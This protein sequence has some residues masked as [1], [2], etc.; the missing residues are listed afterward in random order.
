MYRLPLIGE[1]P[2]HTPMGDGSEVMGDMLA[3][4]E[5]KRWDHIV[6]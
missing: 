6:H 3:T 5:A 1:T 4:D 2:V